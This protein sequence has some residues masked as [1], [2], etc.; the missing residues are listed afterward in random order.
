[1][2]LLGPHR[3]ESPSCVDESSLEEEAVVRAREADADRANICRKVAMSTNKTKK[4]KMATKSCPECD[5]Q[6]SPPWDRNPHEPELG[7]ADGLSRFWSRGEL[8]SSER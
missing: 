6:V 8:G 7:P 3:F 4:V 5:Q 1:M 2:V